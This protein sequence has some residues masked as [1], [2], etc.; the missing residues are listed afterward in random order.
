[1]MWGHKS[2]W[3]LKKTAVYTSKY[4]SI[5]LKTYNLQPGTTV[6]VGVQIIV[7]KLAG[8]N[9]NAS[10]WVLVGKLCLSLLS[11]GE[12]GLSVTKVISFPMCVNSS[13]WAGLEVRLCNNVPPAEP[14]GLEQFKLLVC[15]EQW[16]SV[17]EKVQVFKC[18]FG[19]TE[20]QR[21]RHLHRKKLRS[22]TAGRH[23][24]DVVFKYVLNTKKKSHN[25]NSVS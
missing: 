18:K 6:L 13:S 22:A 1:M 19:S 3:E 7:R 12:I 2:L 20:S 10:L 11:G 15:V 16:E 9:S 5:Y 23:A 24:W 25:S 21:W 8:N 4:S 17:C 14:G